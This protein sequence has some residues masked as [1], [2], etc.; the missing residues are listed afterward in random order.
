VEGDTW[1]KKKPL[2]FGGNLAHS[3]VSWG[4]GHTMKHFVGL[5]LHNMSLILD[6]G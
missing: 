6:I 4:Q 3:T 1:A 5:W 2:D